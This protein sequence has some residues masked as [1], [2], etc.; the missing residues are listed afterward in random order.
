M[1]NAVVIKETDNTPMAIDDIID[2]V[3][4][5]QNVMNRV[6]TKDEHYGVI[7]GTGNKPTLLKPGAEKLCMTFRLAPQYEI[8]VA[9]LGNNHREYE[10]I[11]NLTAIQTGTFLGAGVG[12]CN[13]MESKYRYRSENTGRLVPKNYWDT[14]DPSVLGGTQFKAKKKD[15]QWLIF[16]QIEHNNPADYYNTVKKM[17]KKRAFVDAVLTVTA[18]SDIFAQD[19]EDMPFINGGEKTS[20]DMPAEKKEEAQPVE[21]EN[22]KQVADLC[23]WLDEVTGPVLKKARLEQIKT[24]SFPS[25]SK[26]DQKK[27]T[28]HYNNSV[29]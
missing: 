23:V 1:E 20:I 16:E 15:K 22:P 26:A 29:K 24:K 8:T 4:L 5:I 27:I 18:A 21:A 9:D 7:P 13:T 10:V 28:E 14:K 2:Q 3:N 12:N 25:L 6:M 19:V 11:C 17:A